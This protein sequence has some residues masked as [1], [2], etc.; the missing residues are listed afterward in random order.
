MSVKL[1][2]YIFFIFILSIHGLVSAQ[3]DTPPA[4]PYITHVSVDTA[5]NNSLIYWTKSTSPDV[6]WYLLY[7]EIQT[8]NGLEGIKFDSVSADNDSYIHIDGGAEKEKILYSVTALDSSKNESLRKPGLH[9]TIHTSLFYDSCNNNIKVE[10]NKYIGWNNNVSGYRLFYK[11]NEGSFELLSGVEYSDTIYEHNNIQENNHYEYFIEAVKNDG[12]VS[13][14]NIAGKFTYMPVSPATLN[15]EYVTVKEKNKL[16]ISYIFNNN[17]EINDFALMRSADPL[18]DFIIINKENNVTGSPAVFQDDIITSV[19]NYYYKIGAVNSCNRVIGESNYGVNLLL[20]ADTVNN[21]I[22]LRWNNYAEWSAGVQEYRIY[23]NDQ[24]GDFNLVA[25]TS[26]LSFSDDLSAIYNTGLDG[27]ISYYVMAVRSGD[28]QT[29]SSNILKVRVSTL[30]KIPNAFTPNSDGKNDIFRPVLSF[31]P[32]NFH[33]LIYDRTGNIIFETK[34]FS[35]GWDGSVNESGMA[36]QGVY[37]YHIQFSSK[38]GTKV[39][40]T[41]NLTL[42]YP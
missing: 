24:N 7:Y 22:N 4:R 15:L 12:L 6:E 26:S 27:E 33:M 3:D 25:S 20:Q 8:A 35:Q 1:G 31:Y 16:E 14:S 2:K 9:S 29:C 17:S 28:E 38:N 32:A 13:R 42:F 5:N 41:G 19:D 34:N 21:N 11:Q 18:A 40:K 10:W 37:M 23:R 36:P 30:I 39:N